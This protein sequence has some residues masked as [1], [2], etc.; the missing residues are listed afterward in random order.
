MGAKVGAGFASAASSPNQG[1]SCH[2]DCKATDQKLEEK[3]G[4]QHSWRLLGTRMGSAVPAIH[5]A[6][7]RASRGSTQLSPRTPGSWL[8]VTQLTTLRN[9]DTVKRTFT[10]VTSTRS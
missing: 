6:A 4:P 8:L 3:N 10:E 9:W 5:E 7:P 1:R 2:T